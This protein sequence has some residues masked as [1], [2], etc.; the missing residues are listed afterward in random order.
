M[1]FAERT[2]GIRDGVR[3]D[4]ER[5]AR[6]APRCGWPGGG[7]SF[8]GG[9]F[10]TGVALH[11]RPRAI[12]VA[13]CVCSTNKSDGE[14][15]RGDATEKRAQNDG[16]ASRSKG[17]NGGLRYQRSGGGRKNSREKARCTFKMDQMSLYMVCSM[18]FS[19]SYAKFS[20]KRPALR[21]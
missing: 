7:A 11:Q 10:P 12:F 1:V 8:E 19:T 14:K 6:I 15:Q 5:F 3:G 2:A 4:I 21:P 17:G 16:H 13:F 18:E 9:E 20:W